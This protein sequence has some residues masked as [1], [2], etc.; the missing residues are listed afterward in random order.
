MTAEWRFAIFASFFSLIRNDGIDL[1][2][3]GT[4]WPAPDA[5]R[6]TWTIAYLSLAA[7]KN[8]APLFREYGIGTSPTTGGNDTPRSP[9]TS[10]R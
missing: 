8:L 7:G 1:G 6:S 10:I 5:R 2:K 9:S 3:I 4:P